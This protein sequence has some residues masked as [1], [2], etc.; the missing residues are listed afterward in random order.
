MR[1]KLN[2]SK[3]CIETA[4]RQLYNRSLS[5]Y[6]KAGNREKPELE[7]V[8]EILVQ[9]LEQTDFKKLRTEHVE[10]RGG[11]PSLIE[12]ALSESGSFVIYSNYK[13]LEY[14]KK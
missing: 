4:S 11:T 1:I 14:L 12:I 7:R 6:F 13:I 8:I 5:K 9:F 2:L 3:V 10:L